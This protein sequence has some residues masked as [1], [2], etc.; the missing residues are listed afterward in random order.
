MSYLRNTV[1]LSPIEEEC[2]DTASPI[3]DGATLVDDWETCTF[4]EDDEPMMAP[5]RPVS[6]P[7]PTTEGRQPYRRTPVMAYDDD[8]YFGD[9]EVPLRPAIGRI[10]DLIRIYGVPHSPPPPTPVIR[11]TD[12]TDTAGIPLFRLDGGAAPFTVGGIVQIRR[13]MAYI[14][15]PPSQIPAQ[16]APVVVEE[17]RARQSVRRQAQRPLHID[18]ARRE[19]YHTSMIPPV[20]GHNEAMDEFVARLHRHMQYVRAFTHNSGLD[21]Y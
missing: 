3:L 9:I 19:E 1:P 18:R 6:P 12:N 4:V 14:C 10:V 2:T 16:H 7:P 21:V 11:P 17:D 5:E 8:V 13:G 15:G 20:L